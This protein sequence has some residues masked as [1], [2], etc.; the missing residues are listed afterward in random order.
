MRSTGTFEIVLW[1]L[2]EFV[3]FLFFCT[4]FVDVWVKVFCRVEKFGEMIKKINEIF[5][6][7]Q[8]VCTNNNRLFQLL[9]WPKKIKIQQICL[10]ETDNNNKENDKFFLM[11]NAISFYSSFFFLFF[12]QLQFIW[13]MQRLSR[14][15]TE[16]L[17]TTGR[18]PH[19]ISTSQRLLL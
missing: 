13:D 16:R 12:S 5:F 9:L 4:T 18:L 19:L 1:N 7:I 8:S 17:L 6:I 10:L 11:Y 3:L 15:P 2:W 14:V